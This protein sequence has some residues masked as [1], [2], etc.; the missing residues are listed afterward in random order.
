MIG[1]ATGGATISG[2]VTTARGGPEGNGMQAHAKA[3]ALT[4]GAERLAYT[5]PGPSRAYPMAGVACAFARLGEIEDARRAAEAA[6]R[7]TREHG[8]PHP[9][10]DELVRVAEANAWLDRPA[11]TERLLREAEKL[12]PSIAHAGWRARAQGL[13]AGA[14]VLIGPLGPAEE[15]ARSIEDP[16]G[17]VDALLLIARSTDPGRPPSGVG[18][19]AARRLVDEADLACQDIADLGRLVLARTMVAAA[20]AGQ[21]RADDAWRAANEAEQITLYVDEQRRAG[22]CAQVSIGFARAGDAGRAYRAARRAEEIAGPARAATWWRGAM[23]QVVEAYARAGQ[24]G[25]AAQLADGLDDSFARAGA[26]ARFA[27][28]LADAGDVANA[29]RIVAKIGPDRQLQQ[30]DAMLDIVDALIARMR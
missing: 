15:L 23:P 29:E 11:E 4:N 9:E 25:R 12:L 10:V 26:M 2:N 6:G 7:L 20:L 1:P 16:A 18:P 5:L 22:A 13:V 30:V 14:L 27:R 17:R 24:P 28:A 21:G 8:T 19:G 3:A